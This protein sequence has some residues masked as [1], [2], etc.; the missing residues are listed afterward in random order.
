M[1]YFN[2]FT[3]PEFTRCKSGEL[4]P[5]LYKER[6]KATLRW[7]GVSEEKYDNKYISSLIINRDLKILSNKGFIGLFS[8]SRILMHFEA[9]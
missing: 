9:E 7:L 2:F 6:G 8:H 4:C 3:H 5:S 1:P